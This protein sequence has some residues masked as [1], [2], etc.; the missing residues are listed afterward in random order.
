VARS[1]SVADIFQL[2]AAQVR[3]VEWD[4]HYDMIA[5]RSILYP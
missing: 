5:F 3:F 1:H 2:P 4:L